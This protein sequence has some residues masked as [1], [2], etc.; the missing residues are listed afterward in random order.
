MKKKIFIEVLVYVTDYERERETKLKNKNKNKTRR[1]DAMFT[2]YNRK[3][4]KLEN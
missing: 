1:K 2:S 4:R 3:W